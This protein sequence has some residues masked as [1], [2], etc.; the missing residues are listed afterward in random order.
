M[1]SKHSGQ[2][3]QCQHSD[4]DRERV[5]PDSSP[6][7]IDGRS[8]EL[9]REL[10]RGN[11]GV[12]REARELGSTSGDLSVAVK[13]MRPKH[14]V[15]MAA[16]MLECEV[17]RLVTE[18]LEGEPE[19]S[20]RLPQYITHSI[21]HEPEAVVR[22][23]MSNVRGVALD[24]WLYG[25]SPSSSLMSAR[26]PG[27]TAP[28]ETRRSADH[29]REPRGRLAS[30]RL[31]AASAFA[32]ELFRQLGEALALLSRVAYHR[33][34]SA[35]NVIV[36]VCDRGPEFALIDF[37]LAV[38]SG[39]WKDEWRSA[40]L[41][42][43]PRYW[44]PSNWMHFAY[45]CGYLEKHPDSSF[46]RQ[47][48]E[49]LDHFALGI[50]GLEVLFALW[51]GPDGDKDCGR[52]VAEGESTWRRYWA[53]SLARFRRFHVGFSGLRQ[54]M[55]RSR[56]LLTLLEDYRSL[57][58]ALHSA[59]V[60][61]TTLARSSAAAAAPMLLVATGLVDSHCCLSWEEL[62]KLLPCDVKRSW[63]YEFDDLQLQPLLV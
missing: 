31:A 59:A 20:R 54:E 47:Y 36:D 51:H 43:D 23:A 58:S 25:P 19:V 8:F 56:C 9:G 63:R 13:H 22:L 5:S 28:S 30:C 42:G 62:P 1:R 34:I 6:E 26:D 32:H 27:P 15:T 44:A 11:F 29:G 3:P 2:P 39:S 35:H 18:L 41:A 14:S 45:G 52:S 10:G 16:A 55:I 53:G 50:L 17:L 38:K 48:A 12:V 4:R 49:R 7:D 21:A 61:G 60:A 57:C 46:C 40:N 33:D 37:G 24:L